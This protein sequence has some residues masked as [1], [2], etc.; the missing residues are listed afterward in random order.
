[1][2]LEVCALSY[3]GKYREKNEDNLY[4]CKKYM[5]EKQNDF[6][7]YKKLSV[8]RKNIAFA[9]FDG[10]G[11]Y[12]FGERASFLAVQNF[13]YFYGK[14]NNDFLEEFIEDTNKMICHEN[15]KRNCNMGTTTAILLIY[16]NKIIVCNV[17]DSKIYRVNKSS[18][19]KLT[20]DHTMVEI[21]LRSKLIEKPLAENHPHKN[22]LTQ[23]LGME[24][25]ILQPFICEYE[26]MQY[27]DIFLLCSDGLTE[28]NSEQQLFDMINQKHSAKQIAKNLIIASIDKKTKDNITLIVLKVGKGIF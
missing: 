25:T 28:K 22:V 21:M 16:Q 7:E 9:V 5:S 8:R 13:K 27:G 6:F 3:Q 23:Y 19:Q 17:G 4:F 26:K 2:W 24:E 18:I 15:K 11:G 1:M 10:M 14:Y 20:Q 12:Q